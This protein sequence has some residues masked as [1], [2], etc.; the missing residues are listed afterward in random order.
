MR[1]LAALVFSAAALTAASANA[2]K[3]DVASAT[4]NDIVSAADDD[5]AA[6]LMW[7]HGYFSGKYGNTLIDF[8]TFEKG[9]MAI[10]EAC[11]AAPDASWLE[12]VEKTI[13]G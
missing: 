13:S 4:C 7:T 6:I 12:T 8:E 11:A 3:I 2:E 9:S 5:K 10:G 1:I